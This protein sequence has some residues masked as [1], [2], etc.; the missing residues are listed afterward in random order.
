MPSIVGTDALHTLERHRRRLQWFVTGL[1]S[2][3]AIFVSTDF[4]GKLSVCKRCCDQTSRWVQHL[5]NIEK[6]LSS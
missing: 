3:N 5:S 2:A 6:Q 4:L 1:C